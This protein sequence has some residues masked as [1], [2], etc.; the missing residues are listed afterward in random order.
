MRFGAALL[1]LSVGGQLFGQGQQIGFVLAAQG[2][3]K[4]VSKGNSPVA[5]GD[6][7]LPQA[8]ARASDQKARLTIGLLDGTVKSFECPP[9]NPCVATIGTFRPSDAGLSARLLAVGK[10]FFSQRESVPVYAISRGES[11]AQ[12]QHAVL[13][14][15]DRQ[16]QI[17]PAIVHLDPGAFAIRLRSLQKGMSYNAG[18][19]WDPP[20]SV[21]ASVGSVTPGV[22]D[23]VVSSSEGMRIGSTP[24]I[25]ST[26]STA[27]AEQAALEEGRKI[28]SAWPRDTDPAAVHN[29][30]TAVLLDIAK[31]AQ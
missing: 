23:L 24:V 29:F 21:G 8:T 14:L 19:T 16:L 9:L 22:Y 18:L 30:L 15:T 3:W 28:T 1:L 13:V 2:G 12:F 11:A 6:P 26:P 17:A 31:Q 20:N 4:W 25:V 10:T 7:V 5:A 27:A